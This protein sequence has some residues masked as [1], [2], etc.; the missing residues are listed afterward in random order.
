MAKAF[1]P[2]RVQSTDTPLAGVGRK[3]L[4]YID[5]VEYTIP[6]DVPSW[7]G[8]QAMEKTATMSEVEAT[9]WLMKEML[10]EEGY[11]A[12]L[13]CKTITKPEMQA[14]QMVIRA[15]VFGEEEEEGKG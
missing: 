5:D 6:V 3:P 4:F 14:M 15:L 2:I 11:T 1:E 7:Y 13:N 12:L 9:R 10:G 8:M